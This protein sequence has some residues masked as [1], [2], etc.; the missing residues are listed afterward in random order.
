MVA[1]SIP[2]SMLVQD[3]SVSQVPG[4]HQCPCWHPDSSFL[5]SPSTINLAQE[6]PSPRYSFSLVNL[7]FLF[8][9]LFSPSFLPLSFANLNLILL[10]PFDFSLDPSLP[11]FLAL[12]TSLLAVFYLVLYLSLL[13][14]FR[15]FFL[16]STF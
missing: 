8:R 2:N 12:R 7:L 15:C 3:P 11:L 10:F 1:I 5:P 6:L 14:S 16:F 13:D 4:T 9:F